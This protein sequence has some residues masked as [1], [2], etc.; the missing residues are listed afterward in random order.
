MREDQSQIFN[1]GT[2]RGSSVQEVVDAAR[3]LS[4]V[5][6]PIEYTSRRPGDPVAIYA[7]NTKARELLGWQPQYGLEEIV[8]TA[9]QW[10]STHLDGYD[11]K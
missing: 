3:R 10:H 6:I 9:W 7:D 4:G 1:L 2:G 8:S 11:S 5:D